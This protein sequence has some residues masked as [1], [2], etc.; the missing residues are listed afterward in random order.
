MSEDTSNNTETVEEVIT[1][2]GVLQQCPEINLE[3]NKVGIHSKLCNLND[4]I[5]DGNRI[6]IYKPLVADPKDSRRKRAEKQN[7][8]DGLWT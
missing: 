6:E 1:R 4:M 3:I 7:H 2:S 8:F 5:A